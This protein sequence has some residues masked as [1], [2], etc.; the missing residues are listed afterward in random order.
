MAKKKNAP[1]G[2][3]KLM[4]HEEQMEYLRCMED[5]AY[6]A[7]KYCKVKDKATG[8]KIPFKLFPHQHKVINAYMNNRLNLI[9]KYRQGG[10]T[11]ITCLYIAWLLMFTPDTEVVVVAN[12]MTL[13]QENIFTLVVDI[14]DN[15]PDFLRTEVDE[16]DSQKK[17]VYTNGSVLQALAAGQDGTRGTSP[18]LIFVDEAAYL[19]YGEQ[20]MTSTMGALSAGGNMILNSTPKGMDPVYYAKYEQSL[21][22]EGG[23]NIFNVVE[24]FWYQDPR[25]IINK[26]TKAPDLRWVKTIEGVEHSVLTADPEVYRPLMADGYKPTSS[27]YEMRCGDYDYDPK[28]IAQELNGSFIGSGGNLIADE[29]II[30]MERSTVRP[31]DATNDTEDGKMWHWGIKDEQDK[32]QLVKPDGR[33]QLYSDVSKG[34]GEDYST[35]TI[36]EVHPDGLMEQV[37]ELQCKY[38]PEVLA[39]RINRYARM[40]NMAYVVIDVSGG[41]GAVT[42]DNL[43]RLEYPMSCIHQSEIRAKPVRDRLLKHMNEK[44]MVPGFAIGANRDL[45]LEEFERRIRHGEVIFRSKRLTAEFKSFV[46]INGRYDHERSKHDDLLMAAAMG[47]YAFKFSFGTMQGVSFEAAMVQASAWAVVTQDDYDQEWLQENHVNE[48]KK[49]EADPF[50]D[51]VFSRESPVLPFYF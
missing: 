27:W 49:Y 35:I 44:Q 51:D 13:A 48:S 3:P 36:F 34:T 42:M 11:T 10:I 31:P 41:I 9:L 24:I 45:I 33:Y 23:E 26:H 39:E 14:I 17:K 25:F 15:L 6:F 21:K 28:R 12:T 20:F 46:F 5:I 18:D 37:A 1:E 47:F 2:K 50:R 16:K 40:Y 30:E 7:E 43:L 38:P 32:M 22:G 29:L 4:T 8:R 19:Q